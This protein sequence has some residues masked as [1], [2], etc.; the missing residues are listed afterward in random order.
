MQLP[1]LLIFEKIWI[2]SNPVEDLTVSIKIIMQL[3]N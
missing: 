3:P 2:G 1:R